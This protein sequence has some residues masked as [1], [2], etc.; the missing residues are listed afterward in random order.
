MLDGGAFDVERYRADFPILTTQVRGKELVYLDNA[1]SAQKPRQVI[2]AIAEFDRAS[3][4]NIH[5]GVH[6]LSQVATKAYEGARDKVRAFM[7]AEQDR[8][9]IFVRGTTE[10]INLVA[11]SYGRANLQAGDEILITHLEHHSNIVPWQILCQQTGAVL[12]VAPISDEGEIV[13]DEF[14]KLVGKKT[15][16]VAVNHVSNALGTINPVDEIIALAH[17]VGA[18]ALIDGAQSAPHLAIDV[19]ALDADFYAF[20]S[21][22]IFGPTGVGVLY[23]KAALLEAM[24]PYQGGGDMISYVT[25]E[26]TRYNRIPYKFEAGTPNITGVVGMGAAIDYIQSVGLDAIGAYEH[27]LLEYATERVGAVEGVRLV[28]TAAKKAGVLSFVI[29]GVH[30]HDVGTILD[31]AGIAIRAGHHC[32]QPVMDRFGIPATA[33]ASFAFYNTKAEIDA[34][35]DGI[36]QIRKVFG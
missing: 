7:N 19:R 32:A 29:D 1:A 23:G 18:V 30:P 10:A 9:I 24:P 5:R 33:R 2:D 12:K 26:E 3:Y 35:V 28:G 22:K 4:A 27:E 8:E 25:F 21:H 34:L 14:K 13:M 17:E 15:K 6:H 16:I 20:S 36:H 11:S 31:Q